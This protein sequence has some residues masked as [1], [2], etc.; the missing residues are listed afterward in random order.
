[1]IAGNKIEDDLQDFPYWI[2]STSQVISKNRMFLTCNSPH[3]GLLLLHVRDRNQLQAAKVFLSQP[4]QIGFQK[5]K[6]V[7]LRI[8]LH[9][10]LQFF[11]MRCRDIRN[12]HDCGSF[13]LQIEV[14]IRKLVTGW[15]TN[16]GMM[17][18]TVGNF[19]PPL[20]HFPRGT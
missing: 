11:C 19:A 3:L 6:S 9:A 13:H 7:K 8:R 20:P 5:K 1:M 12:I 14:S 15:R 16:E 18:T 10:R 17:P 4:L 2:F